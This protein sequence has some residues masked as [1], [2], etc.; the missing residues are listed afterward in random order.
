MIVCL[1]KALF[2]DETQSEGETA[3]SGS[4]ASEAETTWR[5]L[6]G[7]DAHADAA[8]SADVDASSGLHLTSYGGWVYHEGTRIGRIFAQGDGVVVNCYHKVHKPCCRKWVRLD[9]SLTRE[10]VLSWLR[11]AHAFS[12]SSTHLDA[13]QIGISFAHPVPAVAVPLAAPPPVPPVPA[14][15]PAARGRGRNHNKID[16]G[17]W[18]VSI[19]R[20]GGTESR[21]GAN[22]NKHRNIWESASA[23]CKRSIGFGANMPE[24]EARRRMKKWLLMGAGIAGHDA[25]SKEQHFNVDPYSWSREELESEGELDRMAAAFC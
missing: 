10:G 22:C 20:T 16:F 5:A 17:P 23:R 21:W 3:E 12:S 14:P 18:S 7:A 9:E 1:P 11:S 19:I 4:E 8:E 2:E 24:E 15:H 6:V 13:L 25:D